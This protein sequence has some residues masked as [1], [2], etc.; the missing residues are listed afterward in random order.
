MGRR[1]AEMKTKNAFPLTIENKGKSNY[2]ESIFEHS[3][4]HIGGA[5]DLEAERLKKEVRMK[6][7]AVLVAKR[8]EDQEG[9]KKDLIEA[10]RI[11]DFEKAVAC[12]KETA[13]A[14]M[15][16]AAHSHNNP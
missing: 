9:Q 1:T 7:W 14:N 16:A 13:K 10:E 3:T 8:R 11:K 2:T 15:L 5:I 4:V 12:Q 6:Q